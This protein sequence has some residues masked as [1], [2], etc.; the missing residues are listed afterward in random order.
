M[1]TKKA[2][3]VPNGIEDLNFTKTYYQYDKKGLL[4][5]GAIT[6][7]HGIVE[8]VKKIYVD[9]D[10]DIEMHIFGVV[11][12]E[13]KLIETIQILPQEK[14]DKIKYYGRK[15]KAEIIL[16]VEGLELNLFGIAPYSQSLDS[17]HVYYGDSLKLKEYLQFNI[18]FITSDIV[19]IDQS[20][21]NFGFVYHS[22]Q[23]FCDIIKDKT[24]KLVIGIEAKNTVLKDFRHVAN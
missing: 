8:T 13:K 18:P 1:D 2:I 17:D 3:L 10:I 7:Q 16:I 14:R 24:D 6:E 22:D 5:I 20:I 9:Q 23:K 15:N 19:Y 21:E 4:C 11:P 12:L